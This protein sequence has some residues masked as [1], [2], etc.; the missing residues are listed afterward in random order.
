MFDSFDKIGYDKFDDMK[1]S[2]LIIQ[3]IISFL[4][5]F[6]VWGYW[7]ERNTKLKEREE[8]EKNTYNFRDFDR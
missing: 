2:T 7:H 1:I 4:S 8:K 5:L 6:L 3:I